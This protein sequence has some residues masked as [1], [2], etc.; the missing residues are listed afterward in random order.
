M[1]CS[2]KKTR[3]DGKPATERPYRDLDADGTADQDQ[4]QRRRLQDVLPLEA[5]PA[6]ETK[7]QP[8]TVKQGSDR[9]ID[10]ISD[11]T[12]HSSNPAEV[13]RSRSYFQVDIHFI[14]YETV[15]FF[16][17]DYILPPFN[18]TNSFVFSSVNIYASPVM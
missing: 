5:P 14:T 9:K 11:G 18:A 1:V 10:E 4:K 8:D 2:P 7:L 3:R 16:K 15:S 13:P 12:K 6:I 17:R